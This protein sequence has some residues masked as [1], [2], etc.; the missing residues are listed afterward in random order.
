MQNRN[1]Q[2]SDLTMEEFRDVFNLL[3]PEAIKLM[4]VAA[5]I[6]LKAQ[7]AGRDSVLWCNKLERHFPHKFKEL[8]AQG[9]PG[10]DW[11]AGFQKLY[12]H[13]YRHLSSRNRELFSLVKE[14]DVV[15]L[16][17]KN[18]KLADLI[19]VGG[20]FLSD[21]NNVSILEWVSRHKQTIRLSLLDYFYK[22]AIEAYSVKDTDN[23]VEIDL[24]KTDFASQTILHWAVRCCQPADTVTALI[25]EGANVNA[26]MNVNV[27]P[28]YIAAA[29]GHLEVVNALLA[30]GAD[31][32]AAS[33]EGATPLYIAAA[34]GHL[35]VVNALLAQGA[36]IN[37]VLQDGRTSLHI[38]AQQGHLN[39]VNALLARGAD[40]NAASRGAA[41]PLYIAATWGHLNVVNALLARGADINAA[42]REGATP[43]Y[44]A[45]QNDHLEVVNA[46][47]ARG[48][49]I[50]AALQGG[51]SPLYVAA[52]HGHLDVANALL[53]A[54]ANIHAAN[55]DGAT[56]LHAAALNRHLDVVKRFHEHALNCYIDNLAVRE[57]SH[58]ETSISIFGKTMNFGYSAQQKKDAAMA[59]KSVIFEGEHVSVLGVHQGALNN[60]ELKLI[61]RRLL[62]SHSDLLSAAANHH[63]RIR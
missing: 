45:A 53:A 57:G 2:L 55:W 43:L 20:Y 58:Y 10:P 42:S 41:T 8:Q 17:R 6:N 3:S 26:G 28:L 1:R 39:V 49:D 47:L 33:R 38:A 15:G 37:A 11:H 16:E 56:P 46:L 36:N 61:Y 19:V 30:Q 29:N 48:A 13:E 9:D 32:N 12:A 54:G 34:Q 60:G 52:Q 44:I 22:L 27:T 25:M 35:N 7:C 63:P 14:G 5:Q 40:I 23:A 50:N 51:E 4:S 59:L 18:I 21:A 24:K 62:A 31:I